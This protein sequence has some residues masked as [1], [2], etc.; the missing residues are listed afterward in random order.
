MGTLKD[1]LVETKQTTTRGRRWSDY[2]MRRETRV[3]S[4]GGNHHT[5]GQRASTDFASRPWR[6]P[7]GGRQAPAIWIEGLDWGNPNREERLDDLN[8]WRRGLR[9]A[10][11]VEEGST[12]S[13]SEGLR[14]ISN[15]PRRASRRTVLTMGAESGSRYTLQL[16][17]DLILRFPQGVGG[18]QMRSSTIR[19]Q[20]RWPRLASTQQQL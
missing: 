18:G 16:Q 8:G 13:Y 14:T 17:T 19:L 15:A 2:L 12:G 3:K 9:V 7:H 10:R 4:T 6:H 20:L 11:L 5:N 1:S